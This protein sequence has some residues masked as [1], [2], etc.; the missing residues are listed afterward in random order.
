MA[1]LSRISVD[2]HGWTLPP[3]DCGDFLQFGRH[4]RG[5]RWLRRDGCGSG[6]RLQLDP[7]LRSRQPP[8]RGVCSG[9]S[10]SLQ[11]AGVAGASSGI[12]L[13]RWADRDV[14]LVADPDEDALFVVDAEAMSSSARSISA[15]PRTMSPSWAMAGSRSRC[16]TQT[17]SQCS[18][19]R[20]RRVTAWSVCALRASCKNRSLSLRPR[21]TRRGWRS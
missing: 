4:K 9:G 15:R 17:A 14:A 12:A 18:S 7:T 13:G 3:L 8:P 11:R 2:E 5:G 20:P 1:S 21:R 6:S 10:S 16:V 19:Q